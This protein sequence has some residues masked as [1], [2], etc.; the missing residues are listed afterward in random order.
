MPEQRELTYEGGGLN[1][2]IVVGAATVLAGM[3]RALLQ[4][5]AQAYNDQQAGEEGL[6]ATARV[7]LARFLYPDLL[8]G[9]VSA[10]GLNP[11][12]DVAEFMALPEAFTDAWQNLTYELNP[13]WYPFERDTAE[14]EKNAAPPRSDSASDS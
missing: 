10:E 2:K 1:V 11:E 14:A 9:L 4:G 3:K 5:R 6:E 7:L 13:H 8:A 12:M